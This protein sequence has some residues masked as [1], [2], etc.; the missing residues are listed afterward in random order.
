VKHPGGYKPQPFFEAPGRWPNQ[1]DPMSV[2]ETTQRRA[3]PLPAEVEAAR[4]PRKGLLKRIFPALVILSIITVGALLAVRWWLDA[5][6]YESTDDAFIDGDII[7]ISPQV[8]ARVVSVAVVDNQHVRKGDLLVALDP[9]DYQVT[10]DQK[11]AVELSMR[12]KV[13]QAK[14]ELA[15]AEANVGQ[16]EAELN[17]A[18]TNAL[19]MQQTYDRMAGLD[20]QARSQ[21]Q[22][23]NATADQRTSAATVQQGQAKVVAAQAQVADATSAVATAQADVLKAAADT[24][25]AEIQLSYCTIDAPCDGTITRKSVEPGMYLS[26]GQPLFSI[27]PSDVWVTANFKETQLDLMRPGQ[28]VSLYVDAYPEKVYHGRVESIQRGTGS[29]FS[30]LPAE[31]ATG[32][33][34]KVVQRVPVKIV[35]DSAELAETDQPMAPGMS[36]VPSVKVRAWQ[37]LWVALGLVKESNSP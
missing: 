28:E 1:D 15:V 4:T 31:N 33:F 35:F 26:V 3:L 22:M 20:P 9:T 23:D 30:L 37:P 12:G 24:H 21:Q 8:A 16:A 29:R 19:N 7:P 17:V 11:Q 6:Q 18:K 10:L 25:Q 32:N 5:R 34:V 14:T 2:T 13:T 36:V 27:V